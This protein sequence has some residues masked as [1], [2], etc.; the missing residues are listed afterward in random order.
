M[1]EKVF[2]G[3]GSNIGN[4]SENC[5]TGIKHIIRDKRTRFLSV[6]SLYL[7]SPVSLI[8][9]KDF[10]N[11]ALCIMWSDSPFELLKFLNSIEDMMGRE[12]DVTGGPRIIDLDILLFGGL[13]LDEPLLKIPHPELHKRKFAIIPCIEIDPEIIHPSF[14]KLLK[15]FLSYIDDGQK[16]KLIKDRKGVMESLGRTPKFN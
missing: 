16:L 3:I 6:S 2:I 13:I 4:S 7:T 12:R 5:T 10:I 9:Q 15:E 11:C 1:D 8:A 14:N